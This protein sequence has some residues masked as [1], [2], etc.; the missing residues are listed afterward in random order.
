MAEVFV[1]GSN[2]AGRHGKGAAKEAYERW[3]AL[4]GQGVGRH[5]N[6]YAI[7]TKDYILRPLPLDKIKSYIEL[8]KEHAFYHQDD[9]FRLTPIGCGFAGYKPEQIGPL[10]GKV[11]YN[12]KIPKEFKPFVKNTRNLLL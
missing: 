3:G 10:F 11:P 8:F 1:F 2:L 9:V 5:G 6:S 4:Y 12:V 7:P